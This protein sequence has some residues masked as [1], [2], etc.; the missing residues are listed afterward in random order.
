M[1]PTCISLVLEILAR[2]S[3]TSANHHDPTNNAALSLL[4]AA[5]IDSVINLLSDAG[6]NHTQPF[7]LAYTYQYDGP[8]TEAENVLFTIGDKLPTYPGI[9]SHG[10]AVY[11][12]E[13]LTQQYIEEFLV[14]NFSANW[15]ITQ[16]PEAILTYDTVLR[17]AAVSYAEE[18]AEADTRRRKAGAV[19]A[20]LG[21]LE[22]VSMDSLG[23][24]SR[25]CSIC[26][27]MRSSIPLTSH[28]PC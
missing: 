4:S 21:G 20:F 1:A 17:E 28:F 7:F 18:K 5:S 11:A 3:K 22:K 2:G 25:D 14:R 8:L 13:S 9:I 10:T 12:S 23:E 27:G 24:D 6:P 16:D 26:R 19:A 15:Y